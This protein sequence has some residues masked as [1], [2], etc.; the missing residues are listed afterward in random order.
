MSAKVWLNS[1][2]VQIVLL[3]T[4]ALF[5]LGAVAIYQ[6]SRV[7]AQ[8][9]RNADLALL[10]LT[11]QAAKAEELT[12][13]RAFGAA[14]FLAAVAGDF[15]GNPER[16]SRDLQRYVANNE[17]YS[18]VGIV[19]VS[20]LM[21]C[22]SSGQTFDFSD[23]PDFDAIIEAQERTVVLNRAA[24]LSNQSVLVVSEPLEINGEFSGFISISIPLGRLPDT[25]DTMVELGLK[26]LVMI[27]SQGEIL[28][29]R[30][31]P[32]AAL[33]EMPADRTLFEIVETG[34]DAFQSVNRVGH[35]RA[36]TVV[37]IEGSPVSVLSVWAVKDGL[38]SQVSAYLTPAVFPVLMWL[39]SMAV[40]M[41]SIY[42]LVTRH[43]IQ[44]RRDMDNFGETREVADL[45]SA[46]MPNE[47]RVLADNFNNLTVDILHDEAAM[48][49]SVREKNVLIKEVHHRVKNNLQLISSI[50]NMQIRRAEHDETKSV[51][52]RIQDRVL[53]LATIHRDLYQS[54]SGGRVNAQNLISEIVENTADLAVAEHSSL[55]IKTDIDAVLLYPDQAVPL[56]LM[57]AEGM[58]NAMKYIGA[59]Q[60]GRPFIHASLKQDGST[61]T[62]ALVNS[63]GGVSEIEST[64][65]G[66]QLINAFAMQLGG[67]LDLED[68]GGTY[69]MRIQFE[70]EEF[71]AEARDY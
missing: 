30:D 38:A 58:T 66:G 62:F 5:P 40:A 46:S 17:T 19:P 10:A 65:L 27:N 1:L 20:G 43:L 37:P 35:W 44:L 25:T 53:S 52:G 2:S 15:V 41:L 4:L 36:Y 34:N 6:T 48:E 68:A 29:S 13:E 51:L 50:M 32:E 61:C 7:E 60:T 59:G 14:S 16:C 39:A 3:L 31:T 70:I 71:V 8:S 28:T 69:T 67:Q 55:E 47:I 42:T 11:G 26:E 57:V 23:W 45:P 22:S 54:Q 56:S 18:F 33:D 49:N 24:P 64:G 9:S 12:I 63:T 21:T